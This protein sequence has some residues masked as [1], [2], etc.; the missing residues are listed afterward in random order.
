L[1]NQEGVVFKGM[2]VDPTLY[3]N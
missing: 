1:S 3:D 2:Y